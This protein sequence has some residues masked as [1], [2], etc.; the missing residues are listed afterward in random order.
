[1]YRSQQNP[2]VPSLAA[3]AAHARGLAEGNL[4]DLAHAIELF[5]CGPRPLTVA[6]AVEDFGVRSVESGA[7]QQAV[8]AFGRALALYAGAGAA[9][10]AARLRGRLRALGVR[11]RLVG[12][13]R[14]R[15]GWEAL[16]DSELEVARL[17][18]QGF[19]NREAAERLFVSHYTISGHL[20]SIYAKLN[21]NSR[22]ELTRLVATHDSGS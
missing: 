7:T 15:N 13:Q 14:P 22:V 8:D 2:N 19:T 4:V 20:R 10:D 5:V 18:A 11:R 17:V 12:P 6:A 3:S 21:V 9:W 1:M 16:T